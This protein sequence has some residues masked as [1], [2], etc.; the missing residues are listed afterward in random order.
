MWWKTFSKTTGL[1]S[2]NQTT[3]ERQL[4]QQWQ[5]QQEITLARNLALFSF[6]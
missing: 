5:L 4:F 1:I 2:T 3:S 6:S